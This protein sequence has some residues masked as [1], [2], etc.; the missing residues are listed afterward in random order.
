MELSHLSKGGVIVVC[1]L[2]SCS[3]PDADA[4]KSSTSD[5]DVD[6]IGDSDSIEADPFGKMVL[7]PKGK[8]IFGNNEGLE[9][10]TP[11]TEQEVEAFYMD[12]YPVTVGRFQKFVQETQYRTQS[13]IFGNSGVLNYETGEWELREGANWKFPLGPTYPRAK[14]NHPVTHVS[15]NDA[16][17][18]CK[19]AGKRLP[20]EVEWEYAAK[21]AGRKQSTF[22]WGNE[23][24]G[25]SE[26]RANT[27]TG[28]FPMNNTGEDGFLYTNPVGFYGEN[29]SGLYDMA[30]NVWEWCADD[31][32]YYDQRRE[33]ELIEDSVVYKVHRGGSFLCHSSYCYGYRSTARSATSPETGLF[34]LGFRCAKDTF[35]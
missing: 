8:F 1:L 24:V 20:T 7:L 22:W 5:E 13:E 32:G 23:T 10:E 29:E 18:Y 25:E 31:Y 35:Q 14:S 17:A 27:W 15:W 2:M 28:V 30:G 19:W 11:E 26:Y 12:A 16:N 3:N 33:M 34:H 4:A 21:S 9:H 6:Y